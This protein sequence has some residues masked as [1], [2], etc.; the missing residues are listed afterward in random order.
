MKLHRQIH[1]EANFDDYLHKYDIPDHLDDFART[2]HENNI[3]EQMG[4]L[5]V[6][7]N[8]DDSLCFKDMMASF[9]ADWGTD[10]SWNYLTCGWKTFFLESFGWYVTGKMMA[11]HKKS[12]PNYY[13]CK[14]ATDSSPI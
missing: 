12:V 2:I 14:D 7:H 9:H 1:N 4:Y 11:S 8:D 5:Y 13:K 3:F 6:I 10:P